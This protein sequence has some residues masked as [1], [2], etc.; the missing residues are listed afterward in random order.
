[1][2]ALS[3]LLRRH[4]ALL[5][6]CLATAGWSF[7]FGLGAPLSSLWLIKAGYK[8]SVAG[9]NTSICYLGMALTSAAVPWLMRRWGRGCTAA[10]MIAFG[11]TTAL[12][13]WGFGV[14][15]WFLVRLAGGAAGAM[16]IVPLETYVNRGSAPEHRARNFG[17]YAVAITLGYALGN[18]VGLDMYEA[19]PLLAFAVGG[20]VAVLAGC[21]VW[22][23]LPP[24]PVIREER[25]PRPPLEIRRNFLSYGSAWNQGF[26]EGVMITFLSKD[27]LNLGL[28][29][30]A[31]AWLTSLAVVGVLLCQLPVAWLADRVGRAR[32]LLGCYGL[33]LIGWGALP[34]C[35]PSLWLALW[36]FLIGAGSGAFYP[37]GLALLGERLP[38]SALDRANAC[39]LAVECA[40]CVAGPV[41]IGHARD[42]LGAPA[43]CPAVQAALLLSLLLWVVLRLSDRKRHQG[44]TGRAS[45]RQ[46][47]P[48]CEA[49]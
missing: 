26:L 40:G 7:G 27:L 36:L 18:W 2:H 16:S 20:S 14:S 21:L 43:T 11:V 28:T 19:A 37:L 10:G 4:Q 23:A 22:L 5:V 15:W 44:V 9:E 39:Y 25:G 34:A 49:A 32:V 47:H 3:G 12:F 45:E 41:V 38:G 17:F 29:G 13:P 42:W 48:A 6:I 24:P 33:V 35:G 1:M 31:V 30:N 8:D 46:D